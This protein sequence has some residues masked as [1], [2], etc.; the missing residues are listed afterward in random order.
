MGFHHASSLE[1]PVTCEFVT[2][3]QRT[4]HDLAIWQNL[5]CK[6]VLS[7]YQMCHMSNASHKP[8][9]ICLANDGMTNAYCLP[10]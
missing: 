8:D 4:L 10:W 6:D 7:M 9:N 5:L 2:L 3:R 1:G